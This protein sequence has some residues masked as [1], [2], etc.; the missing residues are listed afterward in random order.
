MLPARS[1]RPQ[2]DNCGKVTE[3]VS[4]CQGAFKNAYGVSNNTI[5]AALKKIVVGTSKAVSHKTGP[6]VHTEQ[7]TATVVWLKDFFDTNAE[8]LPACEGQTMVW[9]LSAQYTKLMV[10]NQHKLWCEVTAHMEPYTS[11]HFNRIWTE[12]FGHVR[13]PAR[14]QF[15]QC[16]T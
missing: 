13:I 15:S 1:P 2:V 3:K 10:Y 4:V 12:E 16:G 7:R 14:N 5:Q 9:H 8:R 11:E 6:R